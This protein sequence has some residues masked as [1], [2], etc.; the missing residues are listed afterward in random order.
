MSVRQNIEDR[1][2]ATRKYALANVCAI[3]TAAS[4]LIAPQIVRP[5]LITVIAIYGLALAFN[6][7][8]YLRAQQA[9]RIYEENPAAAYLTEVRQEFRISD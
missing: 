8:S 1:K 7:Y 2:Q 9:Q 5:L 4:A 6:S 3:V